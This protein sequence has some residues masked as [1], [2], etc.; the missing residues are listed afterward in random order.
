MSEMHG[1]KIIRIRCACCRVAFDVQL[2]GSAY[3]QAC[4]DGNH[5]KCQFHELI[6]KDSGT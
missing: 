4:I 5:T 6:K 2:G 3:C 1:D